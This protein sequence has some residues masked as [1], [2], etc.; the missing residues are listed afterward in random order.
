METLEML[1]AMGPEFSACSDGTVETWL[2]IVR[3]MVSRRQFGS[4]YQQALCA[5]ACHRMKLAGL[6]Q[7]ET[8]LEAAAALGLQV[9]SVSE[10]GS[11]IRFQSAGQ[12]TEAQ[13]SYMG[14]TAYGR[15]YLQLRRSAVVPILSF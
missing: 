9:E 14:S 7:D 1:R 8:G 5:L 12:L 15:L 2:E 11:A 13:S 3:P 6:G 10:G 4:L